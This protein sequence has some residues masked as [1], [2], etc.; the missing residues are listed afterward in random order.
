MVGDASRLAELLR[1]NGRDGA[2]N[3]IVSSHNFEHLPNPLGF[4]QDCGDLLAD[5]GL[6]MMVIPDQRFIFDRFHPHTTTAQIL[7][8]SAQPHNS[9]TEAWAF[10]EQASL[11]YHLPSPNGIPKAAWNA[12][13]HSDQS[14][15]T[16]KPLALHHIFRFICIIIATWFFGTRKRN[17]C[18]MLVKRHYI[19]APRKTSF[20]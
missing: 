15:V 1:N 8:A 20:L 7:R 14:L 16:S 10:F 13:V 9:A 12:S 18:S 19:R 5:D 2:L 3:W 17:L 4:L 11:R 6:L